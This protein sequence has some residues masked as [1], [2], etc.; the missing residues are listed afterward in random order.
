MWFFFL[1]TW[2][3]LEK[4]GQKMLWIHWMLYKYVVAISCVKTD[5]DGWN[6]FWVIPPCSGGPAMHKKAGWAICRRQHFSMFS[7]S[8][9][10]TKFLNCYIFCPKFIWWFIV[11]WKLTYS[12]LPKILLIMVVFIWAIGKKKLTEKLLASQ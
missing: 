9:Y 4:S 3:K 12:F 8:V 1:S 11:T 5:T 7:A 10:V 6:L 2:H